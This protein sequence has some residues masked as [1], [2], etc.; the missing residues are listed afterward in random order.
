MLYV[1]I[2]THIGLYNLLASHHI[3]LGTV[4]IIHIYNII[5][6][7]DSMSLRADRLTAAD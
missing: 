7:F 5:S 6:S 2:N 4:F 3:Y 1:V